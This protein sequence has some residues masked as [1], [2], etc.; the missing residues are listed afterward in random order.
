M[1][2]EEILFFRLVIDVIAIVGLFLWFLVL[3]W[4]FFFVSDWVML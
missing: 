3:Y 1:I 4:G 2:L